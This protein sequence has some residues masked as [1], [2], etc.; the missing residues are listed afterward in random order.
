MKPTNPRRPGKAHL[1]TGCA[2]ATVG[3][4][5]PDHLALLNGTP[6][7]ALCIAKAAPEGG[8]SRLPTERRWPLGRPSRSGGRRSIDRE[9]RG[10]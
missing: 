3:V 6:I 5:P 10:W 2:S 1:S 9:G 8:S 7:R 4:G